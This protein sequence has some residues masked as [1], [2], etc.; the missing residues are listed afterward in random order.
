MSCLQ[1]GHNAV[2]VLRT[3]EQVSSKVLEPLI[4]SISFEKAVSLL[5]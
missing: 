2:D 5:R 3:I 1:A 4:V